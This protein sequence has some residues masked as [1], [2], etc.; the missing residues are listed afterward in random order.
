MK[1]Y[2]K[3]PFLETEKKAEEDTRYLAELEYTLS[4]TVRRIAEMKGD[5]YA[6][7]LLSHYPLLF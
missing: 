7:E 2:A 6:K 5:V 1:D 4:M 3:Q